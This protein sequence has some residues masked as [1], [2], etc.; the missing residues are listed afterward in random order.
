MMSSTVGVTPLGGTAAEQEDHPPVA[1]GGAV[2]QSKQQLALLY[3]GVS[4]EGRRP[5]SKA[6]TAAL[7]GNGGVPADLEG[8]KLACELLEG[9]VAYFPAEPALWSEVMNKL[10]ARICA[11]DVQL[12]P[13]VFAAVQKAVKLFHTLL[14]GSY[15]PP[16]LF[17]CNLFVICYSS[18]SS[19]PPPFRQ[20]DAGAHP[21]KANKKKRGKQ[22][23][24]S[25]YDMITEV[26]HHRTCF[27]LIRT[28]SEICLFTFTLRI[29]LL[30]TLLQLRH[31]VGGPQDRGGSHWT[32]E[33]FQNVLRIRKHNLSALLSVTGTPIGLSLFILSLSE[34]WQE[35]CTIQV[36]TCCR[37]S[38]E[39]SLVRDT[40]TFLLPSGSAERCRMFGVHQA[41]ETAIFYKVP[42]KHRMVDEVAPPPRTPPT[43][44]L[45]LWLS[46]APS[47]VLCLLVWWRSENAV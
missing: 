5:D 7:A 47:L 37:L 23:V 13:A 46:C 9:L 3:R 41:E 33:T 40:S 18:L 4:L 22:A 38:L 32:L 25:H 6:L 16:V 15:P 20:P 36:I 1:G 12:S 42:P 26:A 10:I 21:R 14:H 39:S 24:L 19:Y 44:H 29:R 8:W 11:L 35:K 17:I 45:S 28:T 34:E 27:V 30:D 2:D 43:F 31:F